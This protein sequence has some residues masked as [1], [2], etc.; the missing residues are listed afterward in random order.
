MSWVRKQPRR[1]PHVCTL[2]VVAGDDPRSGIDVVQS[3]AVWRC[4]G[5]RQRWKLLEMPSSPP[6]PM[7]GVTLGPDKAVWERVGRWF[8]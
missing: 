4:D 2:P 7:R 6:N 1:A 5:C 3:G 8:S